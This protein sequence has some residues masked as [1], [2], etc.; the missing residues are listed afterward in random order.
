MKKVMLASLGILFLFVLHACQGPVEDAS[1]EAQFET[2]N[3]TSRIMGK[4]MEGNPMQVL[5]T[6]EGSGQMTHMGKVKVFLDGAINIINGTEIMK[7]TL[8]DSKGDSLF[9]GRRSSVSPDGSFTAQEEIN[10]G[11]GKYVKAT[12]NSTS[13]G[14]TADYGK[15]SW[16]QEGVLSF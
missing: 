3:K 5:F 1:F 6:A 8:V 10:G 14:S 4:D 16:T 2:E 12:G 7:I 9:M 11:T 15:A 13:T